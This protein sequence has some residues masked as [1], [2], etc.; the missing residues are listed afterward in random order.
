M[1]LPRLPRFYPILDVLAIRSRRLEIASVA[2][3]ILAGGATILQFRHKG[4]FANELLCEIEQ[5]RDLCAQ[6]GAIFVMNDRADIAKLVGAGVHLGQEDLRP[7]EARAIAGE[8]ALIGFSTHNESQIREAIEEPAD[9]LA[10]GP[11]FGTMSKENPDPVVGLA[12]LQRIR[13]I[14]AKPLVAIGGITRA[15][16]RSVIGAGADSVAVIGD[17]YSSRDIR[18]CVKEWVDILNCSY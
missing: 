1:N 2:T 10:F 4:L 7:R 17:L 11:V 13:A 16:A 14:V 12:E 3:E 5:V 9:Y 18:A 15:N 8:S 6:A